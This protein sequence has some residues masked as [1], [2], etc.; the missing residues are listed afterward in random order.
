[1]IKSFHCNNETYS[2][3]FNTILHTHTHAHT[4]FNP[5]FYMDFFH[6]NLMPV[7]NLFRFNHVLGRVHTSFVQ[8]NWTEPWTF[9]PLVQFVCFGANVGLELWCGP[10][11]RSQVCLVGVGLD[12]YQV[13]SRAAYCWCEP[14]LHSV[15]K[16]RRTE[17]LSWWKNSNFWYIFCVCSLQY[18]VGVFIRSRGA[19]IL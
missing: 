11:N 5:G 8:S 3:P 13:N 19:W 4:S 2:N 12:L 17:C 1:M 16:S 15:S 10:I 9:T 6:I 14:H 7:C 18:T